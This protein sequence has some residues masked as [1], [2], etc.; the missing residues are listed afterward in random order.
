MLFQLFKTENETYNSRQPHERENPPSPSAC[1]PQCEQCERRISTCNMQIDSTVVELAEQLLHSPRTTAVI[2][3]G[4]DIRRKH[5]CQI[6]NDARHCPLRFGIQ[7]SLLQQE[8]SGYDSQQDACSMAERIRPFFYII[9]SFVFQRSLFF[10][11][12]SRKDTL[13]SVTNYPAYSFFRMILPLYCPA[14]NLRKP[15]NASYSSGA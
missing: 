4:T 10:E 15:M 5:P 7:G 8:I 13:F 2:P 1:M 12:L 6:D 14:T 11:V 3:C 9:V